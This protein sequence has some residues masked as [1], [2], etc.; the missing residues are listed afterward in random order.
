MLF[1]RG[2]RTSREKT[3]LFLQSLS[4]S[5]RRSTMLSCRVVLVVLLVRVVFVLLVLRGGVVLKQ[6]NKTF[7]EW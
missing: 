7:L 3:I 2:R 4:V 5:N 6:V 1:C